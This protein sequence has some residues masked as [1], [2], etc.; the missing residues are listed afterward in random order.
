MMNDT[1]NYEVGSTRNSEH[2]NVTILLG[3]AESVQVLPP[4]EIEKP[5]G[6]KKTIVD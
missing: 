6:G 1:A 4:V 3:T 2:K 5:S